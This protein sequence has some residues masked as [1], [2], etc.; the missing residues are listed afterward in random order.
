[1][2]PTRDL[3]RAAPHVLCRVSRSLGNQTGASHRLSLRRGK[4]PDQG[5]AW[6][7][8]PSRWW[9]APTHCSPR[10]W[11]FKA[12]GWWWPTSSTASALPSGRHC[13]P[14]A[15]VPIFWSC[16]PRPIPRTLAMMLYGD[17]D[18]SILDE[19]PPRAAEGWTPS[20][21][22]KPCGREINAFI[23]KQAAAG[24]PGLRG[25]PG[26]GGA[27]GGERQICGGLGGYPP[28]DGLSRSP[29]GSHPRKA[30]G[31]GKRSG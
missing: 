13:A 15:R 28:A 16:P 4:A 3:G 23:R 11:P 14:R 1:M 24:A 27:R 25:L 21:W 12:W 2:A 9:W 6:R 18:V 26:G 7:A 10:M 20:W 17:L 8:A 30:Q 5:G 31:G 29:G 19:L 22:A